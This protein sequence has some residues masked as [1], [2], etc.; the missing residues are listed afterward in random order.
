M[1]KIHHH[2]VIRELD[3]LIQIYKL[4]ISTW[5]LKKHITYMY[6]ITTK[7]FNS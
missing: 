7:H 5:L 3:H 4:G 6:Y 2:V 1:Q